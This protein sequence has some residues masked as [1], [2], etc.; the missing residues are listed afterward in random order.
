MSM[1]KPT[2]LAVDDTVQ[3]LDVLEELLDE[4]RVI[5]ATNGKDAISLVK[6]QRVNLILL[7][8]MM[9]EMDGFEVCKILKSDEKTKDIP[10][11]FI[12]AKSD[13]DSI[14]KAYDLG[15]IDYVTKPFLP[16][17]LLSRIKKELRI[18][19]LIEKLEELAS[20]DT[21]T[22]LY[23]RRFFYE[24]AIKMIAHSKRYN[25][26]VSIIMLDID[27]FKSVNDRYGHKAGD[28][29]LKEL[30]QIMQNRRRKSDM[31]VRLGGEEFAILL[32]ETSKEQAYKIAQ[33]L[34][35]TIE[36]NRVNL[37]DGNTIYF[38]A[39]MGISSVDMDKESDIDAA[40]SRADKVLYKAKESGRNNVQTE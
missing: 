28:E 1:K 13:E 18:Q 35:Q 21:L 24:S 29:V 3:N 10:I 8:I 19:E 33:Q 27:H 17:E 36:K 40:L 15:A 9:P 4:Y 31:V 16:K 20:K 30:A 14:E 2:I 6:E 25:K 11:I 39:S 12:T 38:T 37:S 23:N 26:P 34:R 7:D 32:P 5:D 22:Q